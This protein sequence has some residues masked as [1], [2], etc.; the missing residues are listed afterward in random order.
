MKQ[1]AESASRKVVRARGEIIG[2][3]SFRL[4]VLADMGLANLLIP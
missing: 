3:T 2:A 1:W 4:Q